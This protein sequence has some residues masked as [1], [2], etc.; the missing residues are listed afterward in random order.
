MRKTFQTEEARI[1]TQNVF[2]QASPQ[3]MKHNENEIFN[4]LEKSFNKRFREK[5]ISRSISPK[6]PP[7]SSNNRKNV[8]SQAKRVTQDF[9]DYPSEQRVYRTLY[10]ADYNKPTEYSSTIVEGS[11]VKKRRSGSK[12][13]FDQKS[14]SGGFFSPSGYNTQPVFGTQKKMYLSPSMKQGLVLKK[15]KERFCN[16]NGSRRRIEQLNSQIRKSVTFQDQNFR[17][18]EKENRGMRNSGYAIQE[19]YTPSSILKK[20]TLT[21]EKID[22]NFFK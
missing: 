6:I 18:M 22:V 10:D 12:K 15:N 14:S 21:F 13:K 11:S 20:N 3:G 2:Q 5:Y 16:S 19:D 7:K 9:V 17:N 8:K 4:H 1:E